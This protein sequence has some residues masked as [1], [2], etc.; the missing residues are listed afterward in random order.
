MKVYLITFNEGEQKF[1]SKLQDVTSADL[2]DIIKAKNPFVSYQLVHKKYFMED[3]HGEC[4]DVVGDLN[5]RLCQKGPTI[6]HG[7][8]RVARCRTCGELFA[9]AKPTNCDGVWLASTHCPA[10]RKKRRLAKIK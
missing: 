6:E 7:Q 9:V 8:I 3:C 4:E 5:S 1:E 10:C 2:D